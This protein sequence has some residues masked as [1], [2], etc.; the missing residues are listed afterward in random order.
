[1]KLLLILENINIIGGIE[2]VVNMLSNYFYNEFNYE[3]KIVSIFSQKDNLFFDFAKGIKIVHYG[4]KYRIFE[5]KRDENKYYKKILEDILTASDFDIV[6]TF[7]THISKAVIKNKKVIGN[8]K[9]VLTEHTDYYKSS[10]MGRIMKVIL[11]RRADKFIVLS[12]EYRKLYSRYLNNVITIPNPI[13]FTTDKISHLKNKKIISLGRLDPSK[14]FDRIIDIFKLIDYKCVGWK[15]EIYGEGNQ[16][17]TLYEKIK[18]NGLRDKI[19]LKPFTSSVKKELLNSSIYALTSRYEGLPLVLLEAQECGLPC[20]SFDIL[21]ARPI[22]HDNI[23]GIM[24]SDGNIEEFA[25]KLVELIGDY[26]KRKKLG[27]NAKNNAK[28]YHIDYICNKWR[29]LFESIL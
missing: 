20:I 28:N 12:E 22:I 16:Y 13:S 2:R 5:N 23:D 25:D 26:D 9:V 14:G 27:E 1:M 29:E 3:M 19:I 18:N 15:W 21:S 10:W 6:M 17:E 11:Y 7:Y 8:S 24:V 4:E